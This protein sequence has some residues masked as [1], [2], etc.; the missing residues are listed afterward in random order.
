LLVVRLLHH[1]ARTSKNWKRRTSFL[2][3]YIPSSIQVIQKKVLVLP[4]FLHLNAATA[5]VLHPCGRRPRQ[6]RT[7]ACVATACKHA[8]KPATTAPKRGLLPR[9]DG[10]ETLDAASRRRGE[11]GQRHPSS[12]PALRSPRLWPRRA[13]T[14]PL[15]HRRRPAPPTVWLLMMM[16]PH[17]ASRP[18][19][20]RPHLLHRVQEHDAT[21]WPLASRWAA[22]RQR[23][24]ASAPANGTRRRSG[25]RMVSPR[26]PTSLV[27]PPTS[28]PA[29]GVAP[30]AGE[31]CPCDRRGAWSLEV[32]ALTTMDGS[33]FG[34]MDAM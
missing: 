2:A 16:P 5:G 25:R 9:S 12:Q 3:F 33:R 29:A 26:A 4:I 15:W 20:Q 7:P 8:V 17:R 14:F 24:A 23:A 10:G 6:P 21:S 19:H 31:D 18:Q 27:T 34:D 28:S 13:S 30:A 22:L 32:V 1:D 11:G